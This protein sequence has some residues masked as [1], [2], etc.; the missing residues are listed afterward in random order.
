MEITPA[1]VEKS[2][3]QNETHS[4]EK[5]TNEADMTS[6]RDVA[7]GDGSNNNKNGHYQKK[8]PYN[9]AYKRYAI[10]WV[11]KFPMAL[12][13]EIW[14]FSQWLTPTTEEQTMRQ[15]VVNR[16]R[17]IV[18]KL[19]PAATVIKTLDEKRSYFYAKNSVII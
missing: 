4:T 8:R 11:T 1:T 16:L 3:N 10:P 7:A 18:E 6:T 13:E 17:K 2:E 19:W 5:Q 12:H 14:S 9:P 15:D